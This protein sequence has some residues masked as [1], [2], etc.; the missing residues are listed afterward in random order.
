VGSLP[1][2]RF[3][4]VADINTQDSFCLSVHVSWI[5]VLVHFGNITNFQDLWCLTIKCYLILLGTSLVALLGLFPWALV[6]PFPGD[7]IGPSLGLLL[8]IAIAFRCSAFMLFRNNIFTPFNCKW[9]CQVLT[10]NGGPLVELHGA[11]L[12]LT[13]RN[14][15]QTMPIYSTSSAKDWPRAVD[16][17][18]V[19]K[20]LLMTLLTD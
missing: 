3:S 5:V 6:V 10:R 12:P 9:G 13:W 8:N 16:W 11:S 18:Y 19:R 15:S 7:L 14:L 4:H 2:R 20:K 1:V 17:A